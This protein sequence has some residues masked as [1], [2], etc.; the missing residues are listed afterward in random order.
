MVILVVIV[1]G[2]G[3]EVEVGGH[4]E[5]HALAGVVGAAA[6]VFGQVDEVLL[7]GNGEEF[8]VAVP[9]QG[10]VVEADL[11]D[12]DG[13]AALGL[14]VE[15]GGDGGADSACAAGLVLAVDSEYA[16]L[17]AHVHLG[18]VVAVTGAVEGILCDSP[19][20]D[21]RGIK[22]DVTSGYNVTSRLNRLIIKVLEENVW[23][24]ERDKMIK[25]N[26]TFV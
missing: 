1:V 26:V 12:A 3:G 17:A 11:A 16:V 25:R 23:K 8:A 20:A 15:G 13:G 22:R 18:L 4:L 10:D 9:R 6:H 19:H 21:V 7:V 2:H 5:R 24:Y 14:E